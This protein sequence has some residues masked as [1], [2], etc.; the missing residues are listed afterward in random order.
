MDRTNY[1]RWSE[2]AYDPARLQRIAESERHE[3]VDSIFKDLLTGLRQR[4]STSK[5]GSNA[6]AP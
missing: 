4:F 2:L 3:A 5:S 6:K 1:E